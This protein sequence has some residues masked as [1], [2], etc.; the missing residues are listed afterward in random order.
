[1]TQEIFKPLPLLFTSH[2]W[3]TGGLQNADGQNHHVENHLLWNLY[4]SFL[5]YF[6]ILKKKTPIAIPGY[7][8]FSPTHIN[9]AK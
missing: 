5:Q 2:A 4:S 7:S 9:P 6:S 8:L 1:M 3:V